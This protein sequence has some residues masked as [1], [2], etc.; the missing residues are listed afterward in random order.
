MDQNQ[1][2]AIVNSIRES[3]KYKGLY[4]PTVE[5]VVTECAKRFPV[6]LVEDGARKLLHQ[7]WAA[8]WK[9]IPDY[10][11]T[12]QTLTTTLDEKF[13]VKE[14]LRSVL[15]LQTSTRERLS[16]LD[17]FYKQ[18]FA[19]TGIPNSIL[20]IA[21]GLNPLTLPWMPN[22]KAIKYLAIDIDEIEVQ[23][24][25][26]VLNTLDYTNADVFS[27]DVLIDEYDPVDVVFMLKLLPPLEHQEKGISEKLI[28]KTKA[29]Y[30]IVS[31][32]V[33]SLSG[34]NKGMADYYQNWFEQILN[35]LQY[36]Y[37]II[38]FSTELVFV[39]QK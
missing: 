20:D 35:K 38:Q 22:A 27:G 30:L 39:I 17:N 37:Q 7:M 11:K 34:K 14:I 8:Y 33:E 1:V 19:V 24:L 12:L 6:K 9:T 25:N 28:Q 23:F 3:K 15:A 29:K 18:I 2:D 10:S 13:D 5:R 4:R 26:R 31:F 16:D 36:K 32:P 21:C